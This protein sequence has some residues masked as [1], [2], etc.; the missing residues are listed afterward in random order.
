MTPN[1]DK[2]HACTNQTLKTQT[3]ALEPVAVPL[4]LLPER[5]VTMHPQI[6]IRRSLT[7]DRLISDR[8]NKYALHFCLCYI[9]GSQSIRRLE[10]VFYNN[11][12][13]EGNLVPRIL[14]LLREVERGPWERGWVEGTKLSQNARQK[15][16]RNFKV[17]SI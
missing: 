11:R 13:V 1:K 9:F 15:C 2:I 6:S 12:K 5:F 7:P 16:A 8:L 4:E 17:Y 3:K 14:S 10:R